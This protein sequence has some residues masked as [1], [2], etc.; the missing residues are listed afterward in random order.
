MDVLLRFRIHGVVIAADIEKTFLMVAVRDEDRD[1]LWFLWVKDHVNNGVLDVAVLRFTWVVFRVSASPFLLNATIKHHI[2]QFS[3][4]NLY[5]ASLFLRLIYI[6]DISAGMDDN[7]SAFQFYTRSR[8]ILAEGGFNFVTNSTSLSHHVELME[9][10]W[11]M[12]AHAI[13]L[14]RQELHQRRFQ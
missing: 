10:T 6:D 9:L 14:R 12:M 7:E 4:H 11:F 13:L 1:I 2:E 8:K 3:P 5:L